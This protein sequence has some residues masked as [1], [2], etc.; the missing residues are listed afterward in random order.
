M[1]SGLRSRPNT[2]RPKTFEDAPEPVMIIPAEPEDKGEG[3]RDY[4]GFEMGSKESMERHKDSE[5]L[6]SLPMGLIGS[7][8]LFSGA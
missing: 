6:G 2:E 5:P 8:G 3:G 4:E 7:N 1:E